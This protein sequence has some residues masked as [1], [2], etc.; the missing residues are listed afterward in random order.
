MNGPHHHDGCGET[1]GDDDGMD[2]CPAVTRPLYEGQRHPVLLGC[3]HSKILLQAIAPIV[4]TGRSLS[5]HACAPPTRPTPPRA[6]SVVN[7]I[8]TVRG[9][10]SF[11]QTIAVSANGMRK[12]LWTEVFGRWGQDQGKQNERPLRGAEGPYDS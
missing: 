11:D 7:G 4:R 2:R 1:G 5:R 6:T 12:S 10:A 3:S 9:S 8:I